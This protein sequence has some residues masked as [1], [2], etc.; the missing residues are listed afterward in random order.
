MK[1]KI[2]LKDSYG[3]QA[4]L[5]DASEQW[6]DKVTGLETEEHDDIVRAIR[7]AKLEQIIGKWFKYSE[8]VTLEI[9]TA[10]GTCVVVER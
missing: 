4:S 5:R 2:T 1:F 3:V 6:A 10:A 8:Y 7:R 9:D